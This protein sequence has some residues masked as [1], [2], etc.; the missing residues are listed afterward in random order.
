MEKVVLHVEGMSCQHCVKAVRE[1]VH[2]VHP[3][4]K[5]EVELESGTVT[6]ETAERFDRPAVE[7]AIHAAGYEVRPKPRGN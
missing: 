2:A 1:A 5:V 7:R 3:Q 4:A 6:I